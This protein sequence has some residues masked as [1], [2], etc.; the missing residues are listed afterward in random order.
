MGEDENAG[1]L[2]LRVRA[3]LP[4]ALRPVWRSNVEQA[5]HTGD[6]ARHM[7]RAFELAESGLGL[8]RPNPMVGAVVVSGDEVVG[9]GW[10]EGPGTPHAEIMALRAAG[11]RARGSTLYVTLEPCAH[12]GRTGPC[13][14]VVADAGVARVVAA[15]QDPSPK[16]DGGG[17]AHLRHRGIAVESGVLADEGHDL[18]RGFAHHSRTDRP[19]V[20]L[21]LAAS[22]DGK[23]AARDGSST[24]I[25]S[26]TSRHDAHL[27][28][29]RSGAVMV[30]AGTAVG[31]RPRLTVRLDGYRGGQPLRVVM[32]SSGR[33]PPEGPLFDDSAPTLVVTSRR[34]GESVRRAW[35]DAGAQVMVGPDERAVG[36]GHVL[37]QL[38]HEPY[39]IQD[40]LIE[41]GSSLAWSAIDEGV[42]DRFVLYLAPKLIGGES[43]PGI[44]GGKG[45]DSLA[46]ATDLEI[47]SVQRLG[48]D[49]RI[50]ATTMGS[51]GVHRDR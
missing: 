14:P 5:S 47:R 24:W 25:T 42:V 22:L 3:T 11:D 4:S 36:L 31:D 9:E 48:P 16:V 10:H 50:E 29:A 19:F 17:F 27:L 33:T 26:E 44:L 32:D 35:A 8:A 28:R 45:F 15:V 12:Q 1:R 51:R 30:G 38:G 43:A 39:E 46:E 23:I 18:I 13:A 34:A 41:G 49:L 7:R 21:K 2:P 40:L 6:D 37:D 20:T